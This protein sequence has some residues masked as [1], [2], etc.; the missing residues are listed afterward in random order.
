MDKSVQLYFLRGLADSTCK[1]Y[2]CGQ[3][4][5]MNFY[6]SA[7]LLAVPSGANVL[8]QLAAQMAKEG[9]QHRTIKSYMSSVH[10]LHI[11]EGFSN[12]IKPDLLKLH[13]VLQGI[14]GG[15]GAAG[16][17]MREGHPITPP[18]MRKIKEVWDPLV[19]D[20]DMIMMWVACCLTFFGFLWVGE[21][22]M[23]R[24]GA[25]DDSAHLSWGDISVDNPA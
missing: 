3:Q 14:E 2:A 13:Y 5:Y 8:Y 9:L 4:W 15:E 23:P 6:A 25:Y 18:L 10:H 7:G 21:L 19:S 24:D 1:L 16:I 12:P 22:T 17:C 11:E 20:P